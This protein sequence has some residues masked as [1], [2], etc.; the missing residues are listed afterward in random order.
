[1]ACFWWLLARLSGYSP[2]SWMQQYY[3]AVKRTFDISQAASMYS[4]QISLLWG[5]SVREKLMGY[6]Y[7]SN[8]RLFML[9]VGVSS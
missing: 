2:L 8:Q 1:M 3:T 9:K 5:Y 6:R 7:G 4:Y